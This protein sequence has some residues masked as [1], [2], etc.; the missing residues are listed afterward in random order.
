M[1]RLSDDELLDFDSRRY[2][3]YRRSDARR[4]L[5]E[6]GDTYRAQLV[7]AHMLAGYRERRLDHNKQPPLGFSQEYMDGWD[8]AMRDVIAHLRQGD[9]L[10]G[11]GWFED[12][13]ESRLRTPS[14]S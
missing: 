14:Q 3:D 7:A 1:R 2:S 8:E 5:R 12:E 13:V 10:P 11:S 4:A 6:H 9:F